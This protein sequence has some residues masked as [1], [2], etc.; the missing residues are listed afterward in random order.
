MTLSLEFFELGLE[1]YQGV[2]VMC[3][4]LIRKNLVT[5]LLC[6]P[7]PHKSPMIVGAQFD[8]DLLSAAWPKLKGPWRRIPR[9]SKRELWLV[10]GAWAILAFFTH[11]YNRGGFCLGLQASEGTLW[12]L[13]IGFTSLS[14]H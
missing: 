9:L 5:F 12:Y 14:S 2:C 3:Q 8:G 1:G 13:Q 10:S 6:L 4:P 7:A 11:L